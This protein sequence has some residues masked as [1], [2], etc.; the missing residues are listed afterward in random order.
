MKFPELR[1]L[2]KHPYLPAA[3]L[4]VACYLIDGWPGLFVGFFLS[5][6]IL[7]HGTFSINSVAHVIGKQ[8]YVTGDESKNNWWLALITLGEGWHNNHHHYQSSARAGFY[9]WEVDV[10]YYLLRV[11]AFFGIVWDLR[12]VPPR[13]FD[14]VIV[15]PAVPVPLVP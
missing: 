3:I 14:E 5:T 8:R 4:G 9:W 13:V 10:N 15:E 12:P 7:Y 6:V 2:D 1:W 11:L